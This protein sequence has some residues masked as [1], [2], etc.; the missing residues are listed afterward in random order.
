MHVDQIDGIK[1]STPSIKF[2]YL[3]NVCPNATNN[4]S[5]LTPTTGIVAA[6]AL[7]DSY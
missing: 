6:L 1:E 3:L 5:L 2:L 4:L 7:D